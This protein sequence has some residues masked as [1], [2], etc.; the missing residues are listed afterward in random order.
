MG[1]ANHRDVIVRVELN[2]TVVSNNLN[3]QVRKTMNAD[4][5]VRS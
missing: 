4:R 3:A 2:D 1:I 5:C